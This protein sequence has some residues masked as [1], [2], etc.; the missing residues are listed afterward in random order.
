[1]KTT[2]TNYAE[3]SLAAQARYQPTWCTDRGA[4]Y[5][6]HEMCRLLGPM[7]CLHPKR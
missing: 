4:Y 7:C 6:V 2:R 1:M 3:M 5:T